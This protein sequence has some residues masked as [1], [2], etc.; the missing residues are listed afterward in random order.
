MTKLLSPDSHASELHKLDHACKYWGFF[1]LINHGVSASLVENVKKGVEQFFNLPMEEKTKF[2]KKG[3]E[4]EGYGQLFVVSEEQKLD[5]ADMLFFT[6]LPTEARKPHLFPNL[7]LPFRDNLNDYCA[8]LRKLAME[9]IML[10]GEALNVE[11]NQ[12]RE[13]FAGGLQSVR[14]NYYPTCPQP[15]KV[16]GLYPHSDG[17]ALIILLQ[18]NEVDGLEIKKDGTWIP[19]NPVPD[20]FVVNIGDTFEIVSNGIYK[21]VEHRATVNSKKERMSMATFFGARLD[22]MLG[23]SPNL[24]TSGRPP[25]FKTTSVSNYWKAF[26]TRQLHSKSNIDSLRIP[27]Q[28]HETSSFCC[29]KERAQRENKTSMEAIGAKLSDLQ[30]GC[31]TEVSVPLVQE[32]AKKPL[33]SIPERYVRPELELQLVAEP[34]SSSSPPPQAPV[35]DMAKLLSPDSHA[36][37]LQKLDY[38]CK[39]WG[40]F[41][42]VNHGVSPSLVENVKKG[43]EEFFNLPMEEKTKFQKKAGEREGYGQLFVVSE[44]QKL[45]WADL[46]YFTTLPQEARIPHLFPKLPLPFRDNLNNY[47]TELGKLA[48]ELIMLMGEALNLEAKELR[49]LFEEGWQTVRMSY[50]PTCPQPDKVIGLNPHSD[51][52]ALTIL[53]QVNEVDGLQIKKDAIWVPINPLPQAFVVNVGDTFEIVSNGIYRSIE[54]RVTVNSEKERMSIA[55][56]YNARFYG[57]I[58]PSPNLV[59]PERP[60]MFKTISM[61]DYW[62]AFFTRQLRGK[63]NLDSLGIPI[64]THE[65]T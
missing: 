35:I 8:E 18:V 15:E 52:G 23:P 13:L 61:S 37:E 39:Y 3:G 26:Y 48:M 63:S 14:M 36:S 16:I 62:N 19:I 44:E 43:I 55:A 64:H 27:N 9:L 47:C 54:H 24:V 53:L 58:G 59:T 11:A 34:A 42:L 12:M 51:A 50:Y 45:D 10:M 17:S 21:S 7:P 25:Q 4:R 56:F 22:G 5:W 49:E 30:T 33:T 1:Q 57:M 38:A 65:T 41:Q 6:T 29:T 2:Q 31:D 40:F 28:T 60:P 46:L 20:A 32:L